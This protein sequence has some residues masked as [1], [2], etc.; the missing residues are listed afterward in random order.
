ML[1]RTFDMCLAALALSLLWPLLAAV[2]VAVRLEDG[3]PVFYRARRVGRRRKTFLM[4]KFRTMVVNADKI[5]ASSTADD[6]P[7]ITRVGRILRRLKLDELP[8][9]F[10]VFGGSMSLV[11][12]RPQVSWAV[13]LYSPEELQLLDV[14]PGVTDYAS[15][16]FHNE[17]EILRGSIDPD[18]D[19]L[20]KIA[21]GK[22]R[23]GLEYVRHQSVWTDIKLL[24][25]TF[26]AVCG[27]AT[28]WC[29]SPEARAIMQDVRRP[30]PPYQDL[31]R[32]A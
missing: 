10:N 9:L 26:L 28:E 8:Q 11:G 17:G 30:A 32:A 16:M 24:G 31:A 14:R 21:P 13:D 22:M 4:L 7:R 1:K 6:D 12:P 25:A 3:G 15:L 29:L 5:G 19:Y 2:A 23:L 27:F 20:E 18:R